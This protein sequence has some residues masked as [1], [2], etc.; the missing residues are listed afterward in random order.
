MTS[1]RSEALIKFTS[2]LIGNIGLG[3]TDYII[4]LDRVD[5]YLSRNGLDLPGNVKAWDTGSYSA[6]VTDPIMKL[7]LMEAGIS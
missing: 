7:D 5:S 1:S 3:D 2:D 6:C 4:G